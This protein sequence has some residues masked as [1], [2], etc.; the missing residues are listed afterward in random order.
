MS[1]ILMHFSK[2]KWAYLLECIENIFEMII[3]KYMKS[4]VKT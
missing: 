3:M 4:A 1:I 2:E